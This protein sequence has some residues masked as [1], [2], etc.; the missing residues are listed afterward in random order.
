[1]NFKA[2]TIIQAPHQKNFFIP[3]NCYTLA[4]YIVTM[5]KIFS[6]NY[7][8]SKVQDLPV[9][10]IYFILFHFLIILFFIFFIFFIFFLRTKTPW[11]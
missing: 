1:M 9:E 3:I 7:W 11:L 2:L 10:N 6:T 4:I 5:T 8:N